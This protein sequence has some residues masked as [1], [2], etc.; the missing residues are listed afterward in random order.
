MKMD[1]HGQVSMLTVTL[2]I[3]A[4]LVWVYLYSLI[5]FSITMRRETKFVSADKVDL[6]FYMEFEAKGLKLMVIF[7]H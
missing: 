4:E 2:G 6:G 3:N 7:F 1:G 5:I